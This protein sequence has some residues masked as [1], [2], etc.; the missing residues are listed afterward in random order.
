MVEF[1][2]YLPA[3]NTDFIGHVPDFPPQAK[4]AGLFTCLAAT[5]SQRKSNTGF[6]YS[7]CL[8]LI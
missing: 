5:F 2:P 3:A 4:L 6:Y 7:E 8:A 1:P